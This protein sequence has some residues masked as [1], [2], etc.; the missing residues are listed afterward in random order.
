MRHEALLAR[1]RGVRVLELARELYAIAEE[2][3][4]RQHE[5]DAAGHDERIYLER[6]GEQLAMG[7]SPARVVAEQW[8]ADWD[9]R[10]RLE[11]LIVA[12]EFRA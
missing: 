6:M 1:F 5:L 9:E 8:G 2:G 10:H 7:R 12:A 3:L 4:R 11:R